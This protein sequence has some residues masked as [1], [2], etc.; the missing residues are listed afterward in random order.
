MI[1]ITIPAEAKLLNDLL[2]QA[3]QN[4]LILETNTGQR[5]MLMPLDKW[6]GFVVGDSDEFEQEAQQTAE[7]QELLEFLAQRRSSRP[8]TSL[9]EV[10]KQLG[11]DS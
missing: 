7:N 1:I 3:Q 5:F 11:L 9:A 6:Q 8:K 4:E 2:Q 10:K